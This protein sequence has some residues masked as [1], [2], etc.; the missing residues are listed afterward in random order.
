M[1][2][3]HIDGPRCKHITEIMP[4]IMATYQLEQEFYPYLNIDFRHSDTHPTGIILET[5]HGNIEKPYT[6]HNKK[7]IDELRTLIWTELAKERKIKDITKNGCLVD[8]QDYNPNKVIQ[9]WQAKKRDLE[10]QRCCKLVIDKLVK[11]VMATNILHEVYKLSTVDKQDK[12]ICK[13]VRFQICAENYPA[14][15]AQF[16]RCIQENEWLCNNGFPNKTV[17]KMNEYVAKIR[18]DLYKYLN[19]NNLKVNKKKFDEIIDAGLFNDLGNRMGNKVADDKNVRQTLETIFTE[20]D[21]YLQLVEGFDDAKK[22]HI[23]AG[24]LIIVLIIV[25][26]YYT[27]N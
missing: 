26:I 15:T 14:R 24:I 11:D 25:M 17:N 18:K 4:G 7:D 23:W 20:K 3:I 6:F 9:G 22:W 2:L 19:D 8:F 16:D 13:Q 27:K 12:K 10:K 5:K 21:Y 1:R